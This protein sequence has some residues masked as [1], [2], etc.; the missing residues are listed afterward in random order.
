MFESHLGDT[1]NIGAEMAIHINLLEL[2]FLVFFIFELGFLVGKQSQ[3]KWIVR[4][5]MGNRSQHLL[6]PPEDDI[7]KSPSL[8]QDSTASECLTMVADK[9]NLDP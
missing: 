3:L 5:L 8:S 9:Q 7:K 4:M 2:G 1:T 6:P